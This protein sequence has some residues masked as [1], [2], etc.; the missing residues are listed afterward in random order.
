MRL[1]RF[2]PFLMIKKTDVPFL[3]LLPEVAVPF[4]PF[5]NQTDAVKILPLGTRL[6]AALGKWTTMAL[7][8]YLS[9][10][11][12]VRQT[13]GI[14]QPARTLWLRVA[15]H[16]CDSACEAVELPVAS[17]D[18]ASLSLRRRRHGHRRREQVMLS[19]RDLLQK[20]ETLVYQALLEDP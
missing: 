15:T 8:H 5:L 12:A 13:A 9:I 3:P 10:F 2:Q 17:L 1:G 16:V 7:L 14:S 4:L 20:V 6:C 19:D 11:R 18:T